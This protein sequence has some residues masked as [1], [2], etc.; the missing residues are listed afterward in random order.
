MV[1]DFV[2]GTNSA[3]DNGMILNGLKTVC[4]PANKSNNKNPS[5][6]S[7]LRILASISDL[8]GEEIAH[9]Y[10]YT[11]AIHVCSKWIAAHELSAKISRIV[12]LVFKHGLQH[13][14]YS[15][16]HESGNTNTQIGTD[17]IVVE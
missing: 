10:V 15:T 3:P 5:S 4:T 6:V 11:K 8:F 2:S 1:N 12:H 16:F 17:V 13:Q 14:H 9:F 7:L